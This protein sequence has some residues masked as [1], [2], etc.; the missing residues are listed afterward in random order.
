LHRAIF[1]HQANDF[2]IDDT[3]WTEINR[4]AAEYD[5]PGEMVALPGYE[6]SGNTGMGGDRNVFFAEKGRTIRRSSSVLLGTPAKTDC[7]HIGELI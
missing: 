4:L 6:W 3:F 2:Q 1:G 7:H 5:T